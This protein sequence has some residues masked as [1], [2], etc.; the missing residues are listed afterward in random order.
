MF[1]NVSCHK[2]A[3]MFALT[4]KRLVYMMLLVFFPILGELTVRQPSEKRIGK[5]EI[6]MDRKEP[7]IY[8]LNVRAYDLGI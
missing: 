7:S 6:G 5:R 4:G 1:K 8:F 2:G 3:V